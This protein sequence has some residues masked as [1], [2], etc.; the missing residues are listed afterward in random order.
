MKRL[1]ILVVAIALV[2]GEPAVAAPTPPLDDLTSP[3]G[4]LCDLLYQMGQ[5][6]AALAYG[7]GR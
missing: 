5:D 7:Q 3:I 6:L 1:L 4:T 2:A